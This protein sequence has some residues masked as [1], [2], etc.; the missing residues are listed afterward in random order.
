MKR[1]TI[2][3]PLKELVWDTYIGKDE[4]YGKCLCCGIN[5]ISITNFDCAHKISVA[6]GGDNSVQNLRPCCS[7]CNK[8]MGKEDF[9]EFK[10]QFDNI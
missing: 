7:V 5:Q 6:N 4:R 8:S 2:S 1:K 9:D 3:K 10:K